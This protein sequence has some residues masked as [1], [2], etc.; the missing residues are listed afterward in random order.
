MNS[1]GVIGDARPVDLLVEIIPIRPLRTFAMEALAKVK[2]AGM[3][4]PYVEVFTR[5]KTDR[6]GLVSY[7]AGMIVDKLDAMTA[8]TAE[9]AGEE[10]QDDE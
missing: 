4:R 9:S 10:G 5:L 1:L 3:L 6:D 2:D 8:A 7:N